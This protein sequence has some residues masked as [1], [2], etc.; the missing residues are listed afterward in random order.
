[1][2][3]NW[4]LCYPSQTYLRFKQLIDIIAILLV[5]TLCIADCGDHCHCDTGWKVQ[6]KAIFVQEW[7]G[8]GGK[9]FKIYKFRSMR[10]DSEKNGANWRNKNDP[11]VTKVGKVYS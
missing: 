8:Q 2:K 3:T 7:S 1:M 11:R 4:A 5:G 9:L 10:F 6:V